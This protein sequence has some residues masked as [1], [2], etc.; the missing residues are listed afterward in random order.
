MTVMIIVSLFSWLSLMLLMMAQPMSIG[1]VI[2]SL[3][4]VGCILSGLLVTPWYG[5]ILFLIYLGGLL[6]VFAYVSALIP[7][8]L[9][10]MNNLFLVSALFFSFGLMFWGYSLK[11]LYMLMK[12]LKFVEGSSLFMKYFGLELASSLEISILVGLAAVLL[13]ALVAV[14]KMCMGGAAPL[15]YFK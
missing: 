3:C 13:L 8:M 2:M 14:V 15:R 7:N 9:F 6:V 1:L 10:N 11:N 12:D 4:L 5:Y